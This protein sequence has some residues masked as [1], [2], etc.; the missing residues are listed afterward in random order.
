VLQSVTSCW[1]G[2]R[3][4]IYDLD[5]FLCLLLIQSHCLPPKEN[6]FSL[7][8]PFLPF[9]H[10]LVQHTKKYNSNCSSWYFSYNA[11]FVQV[12]PKT[13]RRFK[14]YLLILQRSSPHICI[15][16]TCD[17]TME[18]KNFFNILSVYLHSTPYILCIIV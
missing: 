18:K 16:G 17:K 4:N 9:T 6:V 12:L 7:I 15:C 13:R 2:S 14:W 8:G 3:K 11:T 1:H 10:N 5:F